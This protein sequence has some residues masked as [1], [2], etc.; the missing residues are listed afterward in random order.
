[1]YADAISALGDQAASKLTHQ[2]NSLLG[3]VV[4][5][6]LAGM[7][8]GAC[9]VL[10]LT[11]GGTISAA[12]PAYVKLLMGVCFGGALTLVVFAGSELFTG[13]NLVLTLGVLTKKTSMRDL[14]SNWGWT[15]IGNLLGSVLLAFIVVRSGVL[16]AEPIRSF[17]L[18]RE[19]ETRRGLIVRRADPGPDGVAQR[20]AAAIDLWLAAL[21]RFGDEALSRD[22]KLLHERLRALR[23]KT[24]ELRTALRVLGT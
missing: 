6:M 21:D 2:R 10:I 5:S 19:L 11:V 17:E 3:H 8:V 7:Y 22:P 18:V 24:D 16:S 14:A 12:N 13:S 15:W 9:I 1:M 23:A 20:T 4:R